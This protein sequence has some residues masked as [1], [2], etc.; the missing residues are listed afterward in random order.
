MRRTR[1]AYLIMLPRLIK[2]KINQFVKNEI[3]NIMKRF[4]SPCLY[5]GVL[6]RASTCRQCTIAIESRDPRRKERNKAY[7]YE[8]QKLSRQARTIQPWCSRCGS[9]Q[10][11]TADHILSL[12]NGGQNIMENI[13]VLCRKCNSSK[14]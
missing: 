1:M 9:R 2:I 14:K 11:L 3:I 5:C 10:D 12:A 13:M 7:D 6:S 4:M 8:W